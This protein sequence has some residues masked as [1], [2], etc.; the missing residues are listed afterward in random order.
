MTSRLILSVAAIIGLAFW[1]HGGPSWIAPAIAFAA[2]VVY[3]A[4]GRRRI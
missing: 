1:S 4:V 2:V 3:L